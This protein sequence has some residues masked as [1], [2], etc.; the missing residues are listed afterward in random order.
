M[1]RRIMIHG[2]KKRKELFESLRLDLEHYPQPYPRPAWPSRDMKL[3]DQ[4]LQTYGTRPND[5]GK[6]P[7]TNPFGALL[8]MP[9]VFGILYTYWRKG[10]MYVAV[11]ALTGAYHDRWAQHR[12][13]VIV[14]YQRE[15][16]D[17]RQLDSYWWWPSALR[18]DDEWDWDWD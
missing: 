17:Q 4:W 18:Y 11:T 3:R 5:Q 6:A 12:E 14:Q 16:A 8:D 10:S 9:E 7:W 1:H 15:L 2:M 13:D